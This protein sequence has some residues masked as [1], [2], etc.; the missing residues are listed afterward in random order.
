MPCNLSE[1]NI[2]GMGMGRHP[3]YLPARQIFLLTPGRS[4]SAPAVVKMAAWAAVFLMFWPLGGD[5]ALAQE[6]SA[7]YASELTTIEVNHE[8]C[9]A[10][11]RYVDIGSAAYQPGVDVQGRPVAGADLTERTVD[12]AP[13]D[14]VFSLTVRLEDFVPGVAAALSDSTAP[15]GEVTVRGHEVLFNGQS[16]SAT[17]AAALAA[18]CRL[19]LD[20][21]TE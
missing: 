7:P 16:L 20:T 21:K 2:N 19:H 17:E 10:L 8:S 5:G 1:A 3:L 15:I 9:R 18:A 12:V 13:S 14:V 6:S 11:V 4:R